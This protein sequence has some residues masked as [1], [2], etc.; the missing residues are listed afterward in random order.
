MSNDLLTSVFLKIRPR[1]L[2]KARQTLGDEAEAQDVL[3]DAFCKLWRRRDS[4]TSESQAEGLSSTTVYHTCIDVLRHRRVTSVETV[5]SLPDLAEDDGD[6]RDGIVKDVERLIAS[7]LTERQ[8]TILY[9]RDR[10]GEE[11]AD[12][13][14]QMN[15]TEANVRLI[16]SRARRIVRDCY[17]NLNKR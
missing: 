15:L 2:T 10:S 6:E 4:I 8:R 12:I 11:I 16:L 14:E 13:A 3:Q 5:E 9:M 7:E 1:L 17:R